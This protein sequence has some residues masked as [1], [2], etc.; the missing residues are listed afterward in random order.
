MGS[1]QKRLKEM[2]RAVAVEV[3]WKLDAIDRDDMNPLVSVMD[4]GNGTFKVWLYDRN[5]EV[6]HDG[7][8]RVV[9]A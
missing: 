1:K 6:I 3:A 2:H 5:R 4:H 9:P 7:D 8:Y